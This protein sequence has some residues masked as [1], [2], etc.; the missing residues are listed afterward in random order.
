MSPGAKCQ[1]LEDVLSVLW[2]KQVQHILATTF[3]S[4]CVIWD[5]RKNEPIIKLTDTVSRVHWKV[6]AWHPEVATQLCLASGPL[7]NNPTMGSPFCYISLEDVGEPP[8]RH[9]IHSLVQ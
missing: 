3:S 6:V 9:L 7:T 4:K 5:L 1:P 8:K 2:N